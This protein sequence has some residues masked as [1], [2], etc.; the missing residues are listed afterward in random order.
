MTQNYLLKSLLKLFPH[1]SSGSGT[2]AYIFI[3][4]TLPTCVNLWGCVTAL[5]LLHLLSLGTVI[6]VQPEPVAETSALTFI[7]S[8]AKSV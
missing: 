2:P 8:F 6:H 7:S 4:E 1:S 3:L 5:C